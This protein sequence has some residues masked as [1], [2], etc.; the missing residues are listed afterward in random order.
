MA[1]NGDRIILAVPHSDHPPPAE[2]KP[3]SLDIPRLY[4]EKKEKESRKLRRKKKDAKEKRPD[5]VN[6]FLFPKLC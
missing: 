6:D 2:E 5:V 4:Q 1:D 3:L